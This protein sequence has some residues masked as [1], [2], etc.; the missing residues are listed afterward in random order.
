VVHVLA[1]VEPFVRD[2]DESFNSFAILWVDSYA[3]IHSNGDA[4]VQGLNCLFKSGFDAA[5]ERGGLSGVS[6]WKKQGKFVAADAEGGVGSSQRIPKRGRSGAQHVIA[7]RM[8]EFVVYFL[9]AVE[10]QKDQRKLMIVP[11]GPVRLPL[12]RFFEEAP[13]VQAGQGIRCRIDLQ[14]LELFVLDENR[15]AKQIRGGEHIHERCLEGYRAPELLRELCS[16]RKGLFPE[17]QA[18]TFAKI[19]VSDGSEESLQELAASG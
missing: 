15:N 18:L 19:Q 2:P 13:V 16:P 4:Q 12:Q 3:V 1:T 9:E 17:L 8:S 11:A 7:A 6:L 5:T 10:I 14:P